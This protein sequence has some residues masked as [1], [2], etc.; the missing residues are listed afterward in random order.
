[1]FTTKRRVEMYDINHH[2]EQLMKRFIVPAKRN[3]YRELLSSE[4]GRQK[5]IKNLDHFR[6]LDERYIQSLP[7]NLH[8]PKWIENLLK[9][10]GAPPECHVMSSNNK[11]DGQDLALGEALQHTIGKGFGTFLSCISGK[12]AYYESEEANFRYLLQRDDL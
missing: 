7:A 2:E 11:F 9:E 12:L 5:I 3:R 1:M 4:R 8:Q 10:K 6:D